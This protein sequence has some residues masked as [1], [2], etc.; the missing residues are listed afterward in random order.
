MAILKIDDSSATP[1]LT[2][3][4]FALSLLMYLCMCC[5]LL[6]LRLLRLLGVVVV[7]VVVRR[8]LSDLMELP[9]ELWKDY[10]GLVEQAICIKARG[11]VGSWPSTYT[12]YIYNRRLSN[13][14]LR[15][16]TAASLSPPKD[17]RMFRKLKK[18]CVDDVA[19][20]QFPHTRL[21]LAELQ[22]F[23]ELQLASE[24]PLRVC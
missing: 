20:Q 21:Y 3:E 15:I 4:K 6:L 19:M 8:L 5:A 12:L 16:S 2:P 1:P 23:P 9:P 22:R 7:G 14:A 10:V 18:V 13:E 17:P 24:S 11:F